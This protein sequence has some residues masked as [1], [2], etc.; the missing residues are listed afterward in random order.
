VLGVDASALVTHPGT[1]CLLAREVSQALSQLQAAA[2]AAGFCMAVASGYRSF[3]R[4]LLIWNNKARGLRP[5]LDT[6]GQPLDITALSSEE[7]MWAMLRWSAL[8]GA[9]RHHWGTDLDVYDSS[10]L[11]AGYQLQL[12]QAETQGDGPCAEFHQWL[13][14]EIASGRW[15]FYRPYAQDCGGVAPEPWHLSYAPLARQCAQLLTLEALRQQLEA[16]DL[17]L[18]STV[19]ANLAEIYT[20]FV[21]LADFV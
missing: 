19:L 7:L 3:E 8:P 16:S 11:P 13:S 2:A 21:R 4:Q 15:A 6:F 1:S 5:V 20:R 14:A 17:E 18:K 9:S 10:R 12:T